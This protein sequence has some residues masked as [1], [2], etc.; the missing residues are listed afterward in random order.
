MAIK[1]SG[2]TVIDDNRALQNITDIPNITKASTIVSPAN[3][4]TDS[5]VGKFLTIDVSPFQAVFGVSTAIQVQIDNNSDFS[6]P[7]YSAETAGSGSEVSIDANAASLPGSTVL[8]VRARYKDSDNNYSD[9]TPTAS[10]T[11]RPS[12]DFVN[13]PSVTAP[14]ESFNFTSFT[15]SSSAFSTSGGSWSHT[16]TDWQVATNSDFS[17]LVVNNVGDVSNKTS[18]TVTGLDSVT[19]YFFRVRH[20]NSTLGYSDWSTTLSRTSGSPAG[21]ASYTTAGNY[22]WVAPAGVTEVAAVC[23]GAGGTGRSDAYTDGSGAAA[24]GLGW[25]NQI[26]V[27]PGTAYNVIVGANG[28]NNSSQIAADGSASSFV[29]GGVTTAGFGGTGGREYN[30]ATP[31]AGFTNGQTDVNGGGYVGQGGGD[32]GWSYRPPGHQAAGAGAGGYSGTGG[33]PSSNYYNWPGIDGSG[34]GGGGGTCTNWGH[35]NGGGGVGL[36]GEGSSGTTAP[37][38]ATGTGGHGVGGSG[39]SDGATLSQQTF[40]DVR[41]NG[42]GTYGRYGAGGHVMM[43]G[44]DGAVRII[45]GSGRSFPTNAS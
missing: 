41:N 43:S 20:R 3:G 19:E 10:F 27:V 25:R 37:Y 28:G 34:G 4:S 7:L 6:S 42:G 44:Q 13:T 40:Y 17:S 24:G 9:W 12:F 35:M 45:W 39:G 33:T 36:F 30:V 32:G 5:G 22:S 2:T 1:V 29:A 23:I 8:Y 16:S 21:E 18:Y 15:F 26:T 14:A 38:T 31:Q 11:T